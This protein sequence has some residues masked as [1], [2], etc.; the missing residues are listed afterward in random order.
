VGMTS[1]ADLVNYYSVF[2]GAVEIA[3]YMRALE[4]VQ[5]SQCISVYTANTLLLHNMQCY[6]QTNTK[7]RVMR[8][9]GC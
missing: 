5:I 4:K 9:R 8:L 3:V 6:R 7:R 2:Y 1:I